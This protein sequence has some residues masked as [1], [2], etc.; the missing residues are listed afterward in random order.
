MNNKI[1]K[2]TIMS[3][4][5]VSTMFSVCGKGV[6]AYAY[7][8][9]K[10]YLQDVDTSDLKQSLL[11]KLSLYTISMTGDKITDINDGYS[12][13]KNDSI[14][15]F[16]DY[17]DKK[18]IV[19]DSGKHWRNVHTF[20]HE[21][22]HALDSSIYTIVTCNGVT[23]I[24]LN[25]N[26]TIQSGVYSRSDDFTKIFKEEHNSIEGYSLEK[27]SSTDPQEYFAEAFAWFLDDSNKLEKSSPLTYK[28]FKSI[29]K[30]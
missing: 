20:H 15:G 19:Y 11:S 21:V 4:I 6:Y 28:Y 22:G 18:I 9:P 16:T 13:S 26:N 27:Y 7:S 5:I 12:H 23:D 8:V 25:A 29:Y 10:E 1:K 2:L 17:Q 30:Q 3:T 24:I 14:Y